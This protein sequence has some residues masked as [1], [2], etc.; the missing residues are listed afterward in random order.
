MFFGNFFEYT[1]LRQYRRQNG[2]LVAYCHIFRL[3]NRF[4]A[5]IHGLNVT[6]SFYPYKYPWLFGEP[7]FGAAVFYLII[8]SVVSNY[9]WSYYLV[10]VLLF[11]ITGFAFFM[12]AGEYVRSYF[13]RFAGGLFFT[14]ANYALG[15]FDHH[16]VFFWGLALIS[17]YLL[18]RF[19]S[20]KRVIFLWLSFLLLGIQIYFSS[21][22]FIYLVLCLATFIIVH[23][24]VWFQGFFWLHLT[25]AILLSFFIILPFIL[26]FVSSPEIKQAYD[27]AITAHGYNTSNLWLIDYVRFLPGNIFYPQ[28][29]DID[30]DLLYIIKCVSPGIVLFTLC[31]LG[32]RSLPQKIFLSILLIG[33][34]LSLGSELRLGSIIIPM[35]MQ[36]YYSHFPKAPLFL[37]PI[38]AYFMVHF[39]ICMAAASGLSMIV[40]YFKNGLWIGFVIIILFLLENIPSRLPSSPAKQAIDEGRLVSAI[41]AKEKEGCVLHLPSQIFPSF[42]IERGVMQMNAF[43]RE[44][45][46]ILL[47]TMYKK[48]SM[49]GVDRLVPLKRIEFNTIFQLNSRD[50]FEHLLRTYDVNEVVFHDDLALKDEHRLEDSLS[51]YP[52]LKLKE[53]VGNCSV[54]VR[55]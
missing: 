36:I 42:P 26:L 47:Q 29:K 10:Y 55:N 48:N 33:F 53:K 45:Y 8:N 34:I 37:T 3:R 20:A 2:L 16:N 23:H 43:S 27:P 40:H 19:I 13:S 39:V 17:I 4:Y 18:Q 54:F 9:I 28:L 21:T 24:R 35:P 50:S 46:Y 41:L 49:N 44:F 14:M 11:S 12:L 51:Q 5:L 15:Q 52:F 38:R 30:F 6:S 7:G 1:T 25:G 22:I 31:I 32:F